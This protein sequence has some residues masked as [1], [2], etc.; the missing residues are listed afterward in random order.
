[1]DLLDKIRPSWTFEQM[2]SYLSILA[3][4]GLSKGLTGVHD[5]GAIPRDIAFFMRSVYA[6]FH[7]SVLQSTLIAIRSEW[8]NWGSF[9]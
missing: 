6:S 8:K 7:H 5:A 9:L 3:R 1:M 2:E 4:D